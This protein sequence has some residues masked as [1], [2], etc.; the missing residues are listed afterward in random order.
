MNGKSIGKTDDV[1]TRAHLL[2]RK[3]VECEHEAEALTALR[4]LA[5]YLKRNN[6]DYRAIRLLLPER[7][8][9]TPFEAVF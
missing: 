7:S 3:A 6:I 9:R 2:F 1:A 4:F 8:A 5:E